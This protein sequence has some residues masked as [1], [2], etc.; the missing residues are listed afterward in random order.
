[1]NDNH[2]SGVVCELFFLVTFRILDAID[3]KGIIIKGVD[4]KKK[5]LQLNIK[6]GFENFVEMFNSLPLNILGD[7]CLTFVFLNFTLSLS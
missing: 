3:R 6:I 2:D 1:M 4:K 5:N 7:R